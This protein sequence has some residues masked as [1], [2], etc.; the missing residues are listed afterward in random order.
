MKRERL[1]SRWTFYYRI[2]LP[3]LWL[4]GAGAG[5]A[6]LLQDKTSPPP[7]S[8]KITLLGTWLA[9]G[10]VFLRLARGLR[11]VWLEGDHLISANFREERRIP[12]TLVEG[13]T[14][15][16]YV[17]PKRIKVLLQPRS[18]LPREL[19]FAAKDRFSFAMFTEHPVV[20]RLRDL[21]TAAK[22]E[23]KRSGSGG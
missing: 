16:R 15:T 1:S 17:D 4:G 3:C 14:A 2:A 12:L 8:L 5:I 18:G 19:V 13:I 22:A 11:T 10:V 6:I 20:G 7:L 9:L 21:V 23:E